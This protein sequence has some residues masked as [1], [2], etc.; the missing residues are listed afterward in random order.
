MSIVNYLAVQNLDD[1][2]LA[3]WDVPLFLPYGFRLVWVFN[4]IFLGLT[5]MAIITLRD[6][7]LGFGGPTLL[8]GINL[9]IDRGERICL[10]GRNGT[11][12]STLMKL[13]TGELKPDDGVFESKSSLRIARLSQEVAVDGD[14]SV[15]DIA[16]SGL[17]EV[18]ELLTRHQHLTQ[19][20]ADNYTDSLLDDLT[21]IQESIEA[22]DV[23]DSL[24]C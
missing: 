12:K 4:L 14:A 8:D 22:K 23:K 13:I 16:A 1:L 6:I 17:G 10:I 5:S 9:S 15:Y 7:R 24:K 3:T 2:A 19:E 21:K 18:G 20:L 11:G